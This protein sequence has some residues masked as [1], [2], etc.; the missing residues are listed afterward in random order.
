[1]LS[2]SND[3]YFIRQGATCKYH[4]SADE[5]GGGSITDPEHPDNP[6][7]TDNPDKPN[8]DNG[9]KLPENFPLWQ[10]IVGGIA[11]IL[12][13]AFLAK[14]GTN[15]SKRRKFKS[16]TK[17]VQKSYSIV[18]TPLIVMAAAY[19]GL[20]QN[21]WTILACIMIG[22]CVVG[23]AL[24]LGTGHALKK[25]E[26]GYE[27]ALEEKK[28]AEDAKIAERN[29]EIERKRE[30]EQQKRDEEQ[31][32]RDEEQR[33]RDEE[34]KMMFMA[35]MNKQGSSGDGNGYASVPIEEIV[36]KT[37]AAIMPSMQTLMIT[38]HS[39]VDNETMTKLLEQQEKLIAKLMEHQSIAA[40]ANQF[41]DD[42]EDEDDE[43]M[44][45]DDEEDEEEVDEITPVEMVTPTGEVVVT[46]AT[47]KKVIKLPPN[48]RARLK[49]SS[50]KNR[51][52]YV[53]LKNLLCSKR[54]LTFRVCGR[55][56]KVKYKGELIAVIGVA[57]KH[58]KLWLALD[59]TAFD[60]RR[61]FHKDVSDKIRY[62]QVPMLFKISSERALDRAFELVDALCEKFD[63]ETKRK[64]TEKSLQVLAYTLKHNAILK[65]K[66]TEL[67]CESM[68]VHDTDIMNNDEV[69]ECIER[70]GIEAIEEENFATI[71]LDDIDKNFVD[72]Q[73]VTLDALKRKE[74]VDENCNGFKVVAGTRLTKPLII[75]A[76]E[77]TISAVKMIVLTGGRAIL[78]VQQKQ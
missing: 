44:S 58:I 66:K 60:K 43:E 14:A 38:D 19:L 34:M 45:W 17:A 49:M 23:F 72:G 28:A 53:S 25:A 16:K 67:L 42:D 7:N 37:V 5:N 1:A 64:Y 13:I 36:A 59:P 54:G 10:C 69:S 20:E 4:I 78:L 46:E 24:M 39:S 11:L 51:E 52:V 71:K 3:K 32:R 8:E 55:V 2:D 56:E 18:A 35:M 73:K 40:T 74:L 41:I 12:A 21:I 6:N 9:F 30:E 26:A 15:D 61:Y 27:T 48:F 22:F 63:I 76:N 50:D 65:L 31:R 75:M 33:K 29:A 57:T 62:A 68:H 70:R 47:V 77:F